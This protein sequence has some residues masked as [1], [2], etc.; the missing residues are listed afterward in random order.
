MTTTFFPYQRDNRWRFVLLPLGVGADD[1]VT[2]TDESFQATFGHWS[3]E[4]PL[5]NIAGARVSG[6]H[7]WY[8][9]V[10]LRLSFSDDGLTFGTDPQ[11]GLCIDFVEKIDRV[12]GFHDH[13]ALWVSVAD[14]EGLAEALERH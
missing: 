12:I 7:P 9:A 5:D 1:G 4:T 6:P 14:P 8:T 10:G 13:S 2:I 3:I 11:R